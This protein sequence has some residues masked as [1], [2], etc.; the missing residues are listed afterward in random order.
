MKINCHSDYGL[1][2]YRE[3]LCASKDVLNSDYIPQLRANHIQ[4]EVLQVACDFLN[5]RGIN[6]NDPLVVTNTIEGIRTSI[7]ANPKNLRLITSKQDLDWVKQDHGL[8]FILSMEGCASIQPDLI[9][10][11]SFF[12]LGVRSIALTH[13]Y[14]NI[15][16]V[17]CGETSSGGLSK[18]GKKLVE[19]INDL[20][21]MLDLVH[22]NEQTYFDALEIYRKPPI[23]SHSNVKA[24]CDHFRNLTDKQ[25]HLIG[26]RNGVICLNFMSE[27][28]DRYLQKATVDRLIDHIDYIEKL[29]GIDHIG[30]GPDYTDYF[31][32]EFQEIYPKGIANI[33][34]FPHME[35]FL[36]ERGYSQRDVDKIMGENVFQVFQ[37]VLTTKNLR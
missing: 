35:D 25:I 10:L 6:W 18:L 1:H 37:K 31:T 15:F 32:S 11:N 23:V 21:I 16:A 36:L 34:E 20:P 28:I 27:L 26:E 5:W 29:I 17:G 22:I 19:K 8:G 13:N 3:R 30:L 9:N 33:T 2:A 24:E 7:E 14:Q 4:V 12:H